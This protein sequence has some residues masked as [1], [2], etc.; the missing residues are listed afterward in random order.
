M[1]LDASERGVG[2]EVKREKRRESASLEAGERHRRWI[3]CQ[4][5]VKV[6]QWRS[7]NDD[8]NWSMTIEEGRESRDK[9]RL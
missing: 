9:L 7:R 4:M 8:R 5:K 2:V 6:S 3:Q 1:G